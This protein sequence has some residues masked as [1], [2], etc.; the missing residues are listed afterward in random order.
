MFVCF[1]SPPK[2]PSGFP[3]EINAEIT[4]HQWCVHV[5]LFF[6]AEAFLLCDDCYLGN[7]EM[8]QSV[9][10]QKKKAPQYKGQKK[11]KFWMCWLALFQHL[12]FFILFLAPAAL[13]MKTLCTVICHAAGSLWCGSL[14]AHLVQVFEWRPWVGFT[15]SD[16]RSRCRIGAV[17]LRKKYF[18]QKSAIAND[19][20]DLRKNTVEI[21]LLLV[22]GMWSKI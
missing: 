14:N 15:G 1:F 10:K 11:S 18:V 20:T 21:S 2:P 9:P 22:V 12:L 5:F 13:L 7:R 16:H 3:Q 17:W 19:A 6:T 8:S 4:E